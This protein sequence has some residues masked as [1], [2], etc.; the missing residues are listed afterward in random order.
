VPSYL[1]IE[2]AGHM[3]FMHK[4]FRTDRALSSECR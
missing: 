4:A 3:M 1:H 2:G